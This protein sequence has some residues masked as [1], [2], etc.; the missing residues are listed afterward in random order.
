MRR[1]F[2]LLLLVACSG[3]RPSATHDEA[4]K[5]APAPRSDRLLLTGALD[6]MTSENVVAPKSP[7]RGPST[8]RWLEADGARVKKGQPVAE[9]DNSSFAE[10]LADQ[11]LNAA[12]SA[13]DLASQ[14]ATD[15]MTTA[16]K[17]LEV[18]RARVALEKAKIE[19]GVAED[20]V[21]R[22]TYQERQLA[23]QRAEIALAKAKDD[24][25]AHVKS[26]TLEH[27]VR[28]IALAKVE[29]TVAVAEAAVASFTVRAPID[30]IVIIAQHE[31]EP[32]KI[33]AGDQTWDGMLLAE[34]PDVS[35]MKI[36]AALSDVDDGKVTVGMRADAVLDAYPEL[37]YGAVVSEVHPVAR[38]PS[39][40]SLR[41]TIGV[42]LLLDRTEP[43]R[44]LPGMSVRVEIAR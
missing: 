7:Q 38:E 26:A 32:R 42:T 9:L 2:P 1:L 30:G 25:A 36:T 20:T 11:K 37:H 19:A 31:W 44:M 6:A 34:M 28:K 13:N 29:R 17:E 35:R 10:T 33:H 4:P 5:I 41:R 39:E 12:Q 16:D 27:E 21:A 40:R 22:R 3:R 23:K 43:E 14:D 18:E 24:L 8:L 15:A